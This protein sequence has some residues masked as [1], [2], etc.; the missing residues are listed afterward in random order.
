[1]IAMDPETYRAVEVERVQAEREGVE[2]PPIGMLSPGYIHCEAG[3]H[4]D[5]GEPVVFVPGELLP[6]WVAR[7]L[8]EQQPEPRALRGPPSSSR[9]GRAARSEPSL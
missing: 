4:P 2:L 3:I 1:V 5:H 7:T 6:G 9:P 8:L